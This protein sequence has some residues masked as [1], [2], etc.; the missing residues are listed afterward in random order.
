MKQ[1]SHFV[2]AITDDLLGRMVRTIVDE[3]DP[4]QVIL[5]GSAGARRP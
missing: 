5:F 1:T 3:V 4:Q 2:R